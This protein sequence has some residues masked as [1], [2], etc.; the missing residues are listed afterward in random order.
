MRIPRLHLISNR[1]V[2]A[3]DR[4][5][6]VARAAVACGADAIHI[7]ERDLP[8]DELLSVV[9]SVQTAL[10]GTDCVVMVNSR[11]DIAL[12]SGADGVHLPEHGSSPDEARKLLPDGSLIGQ[13][14]HSRES[15]LRAEQGGAD[16]L[17]A[18]HVFETGS[19]PGQSGRGLEFI[20]QVSG[21]VHIPVI[22]IGGITPD[23]VAQVI[24]AGAFG[25]AVLS[26]ILAVDDPGAVA[27]RFVTTMNEV[28]VRRA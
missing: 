16:Y 24:D 11:V 26:A 14:V 3:L 6:V 23:N 4:L 22:A 17:I 2:C 15:A 19:K 10:T 5:P 7:R 1:R 25:A 13:S 28:E 12:R 9:R 20:R 8:D 18:G 21:A 27:E